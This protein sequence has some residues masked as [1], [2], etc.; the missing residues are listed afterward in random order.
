MFAGHLKFGVGIDQKISK[1]DIDG[2]TGVFNCNGPNFNC[3]FVE[4][5]L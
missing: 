5:A 4:T 1:N 2:S 3:N